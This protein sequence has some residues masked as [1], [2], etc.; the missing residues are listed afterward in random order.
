MSVLEAIFLGIVQ[1][2]TEFLPI[3]SSGHLVLFQRLFGLE[4]GALTFDVLLHFGTLVAVFA[5]FWRDIVAI[6]KNPFGKFG[7]L[8]LIGSIPTALIG[9]VFQDFFDEVFAS[10]ATL[11]VEFII[12]GVVIWWADHARRGTKQLRE[13]SYGDAILIGTLQGAA[14]LPAIS[15]S[16]LTIM[17]ALFRG[18]DREFAAK[19]SFLMS[20]P[21]ILGAN[22]LEIKHLVDGEATQAGAIGMNEILGT[23]F[24]A[25]AGYFAIKYMIR[26][27]VNK[28]MR[29]FAWYVWVLGGL[30][31]FDQ[32]VTK[33]YFHF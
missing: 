22:L 11:G 32:L 9:L 2:L 27:I 24:A 16:G 30:I 29:M 5:V 28:G 18:L 6:L 8:I 3:S 21:V 23:L 12:T 26:L 17:G 14:I 13:M 33:V 25:V 20:I 15:R 31:L 10:G 19:F 4:E 1:G 7:R